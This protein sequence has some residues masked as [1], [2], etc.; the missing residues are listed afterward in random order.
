MNG[1]CAGYH[2]FNKPVSNV[3][4]TN[5]RLC[6]AHSRFC[7]AMDL[8][9]RFYP[10][11]AG[12]G[13]VIGETFTV[14]GR[15]VSHEEL[16]LDGELQGELEMD[17]RLTI[18]VTG[19]VDATVKAKEVIVSGSVKG[20]VDAAERLV[21]RKGAHLEG[22]VKTACIVI[23]DGAYFKGGID[24]PGGSTAAGKSPPNAVPT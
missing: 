5:F 14:K 13:T 1:G 24:I 2:Y 22:D 17:G 9:S 21:L 15:L 23:E 19:K 12:G 4:I 11:A 20:N 7:K 18:G 3:A 8:L 16:Q 10:P 6:C